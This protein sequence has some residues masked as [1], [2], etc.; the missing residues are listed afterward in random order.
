MEQSRHAVIT[1]FLRAVLVESLSPGTSLSLPQL[2]R[3]HQ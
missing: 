2:Q 1:G 3:H